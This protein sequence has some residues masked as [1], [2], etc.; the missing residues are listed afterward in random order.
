MVCI[1]EWKQ[2]GQILDLV[3]SN[4]SYIWFDIGLDLS[5]LVIW[6]ELNL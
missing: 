3:S 6:N 2:F 1:Y 5:E 4:Y